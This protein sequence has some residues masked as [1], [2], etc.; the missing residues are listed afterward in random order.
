MDDKEQEKDISQISDV[1]LLMTAV[2][3]IALYL[4]TKDPNFC[5]VINEAKGIGNESKGVVREET[6]SKYIKDVRFSLHYLT[7]I[8]GHCLI[9]VIPDE[10]ER[11]DFIDKTHEKAKKTF[12]E[13]IKDDK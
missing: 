12:E 11:L 9:H 2:N 7:L 4:M 13:E 8:L 1:R 6:L 3:D 10:K 5:S